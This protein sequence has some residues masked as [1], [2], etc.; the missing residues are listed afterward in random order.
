[1]IGTSCQGSLLQRGRHWLALAVGRLLSCI[2]LSRVVYRRTPEGVFYYKMRRWYSALLIPVANLAGAPF[3]VLAERAWISRERSL[4]EHLYGETIQLAEEG[5]ML[6]AARPGSILATL[7][8]APRY[9]TPIRLR[10]MRAAIHALWR[11]H[12]TAVMLP[13]RQ[14][15]TLSHGDATVANVTYDLHTDMAWWF[16]FET[17]HTA[18]R[19]AA[20]CRADDLYTLL[21]SA[22]VL[23]PSHEIPLLAVLAAA[24]YPDYEALA[25]LSVLSVQ[26]HRRP[27]PRI[28]ARTALDY[29]RSQML[30]AA[31]LQFQNMGTLRPAAW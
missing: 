8:A 9:T 24:T 26:R 14:P 10:G 21:A 25:V 18:G 31:L 23:V 28:L 5:G 11:L 22:A 20:W 15:R 13:G 16:D 4:Y 17:V 6:I 19:P 7:L 27:D 30:T 12:Q 2:P 3:L 1:M 29:Q